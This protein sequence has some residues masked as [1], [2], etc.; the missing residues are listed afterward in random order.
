MSVLKSGKVASSIFPGDVHAIYW[1][2]FSQLNLGFSSLW[3]C[4][5]VTS[6]CLQTGHGGNTLCGGCPGKNVLHASITSPAWSSRLEINQLS[7]LWV[8]KTTEKETEASEINL[9]VLWVA[10]LYRRIKFGS[11]T[12]IGSLLSLCIGMLSPTRETGWLLSCPGEPTRGEVVTVWEYTW[13]CG[14]QNLTG[15]TPHQWHRVDSRGTTAVPAS[16]FTL[17]GSFPLHVSRYVLP[18]ARMWQGEDIWQM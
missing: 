1:F 13:V 11:G 8:L 17:T 5:A 10:K 4:K 7:P 16:S 2:S 18:F 3:L 9:L 14:D 6:F 12:S 15:S